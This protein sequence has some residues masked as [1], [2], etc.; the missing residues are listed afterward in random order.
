M[1]SRYR[2]PSTPRQQADLSSIK[3]NVPHT[4]YRYTEFKYLY[5]QI[6]KLINRDVVV[7][8]KYEQLRTPEVRVSLIRPLVRKLID[9]SSIQYLQTI[10]THTSV[11]T[12]NVY[13]SQSSYMDYGALTGQSSEHNQSINVIYVLLLLKYEYMIQSENNL[14]MYDLLTTKSNICE[15][16]AIRMLREYNSTERI[17]LLFINPMNCHEEHEQLKNTKHLDSF[18]TLEL[19]ILSKSKKFL[20]Q[21]VIVGILDRVYNGELIVREQRGTSQLSLGPSPS[22]R[23]IEEPQNK[24]DIEEGS[25]GLESEENS[26]ND[27]DKSIVNYKFNRITFKKV[28]DRSNTVPKYQSLVINMRYGFLT[29]LFLILVLKH[30]S[31]MGTGSY[32]VNSAFSLVFWMVALSFNFDIILRSLHIEYKFLKKIIWTY[33]DMLIVLLIDIAFVLRILLSFDKI[34]S[35]IYYNFF[36]LIPILLFPRMLSVFNN[37]EFFNLIV[38]SLKKLTWNVFAMFCLFLS[39]IFGFF[40]CFISLAVDLSIYEVAFAML[41]VFFGFTPAV[42]DNWDNYTNLGR[43]V[44]LAYLAL[45]QFV[46][47]TILAIVLSNVFVKVTKTNKQE[48]EYLKTTNLIIYLKWAAFQRSHRKAKAII[49]VFDHV[50]RIFKLP[51]ILIIYFYEILIKD[52]KRLMQKQ[53]K[54]LKH[55]TFL[56]RD[57]DLYGDSEME[58]LSSL[59]D[60]DQSSIQLMSRR[61]LQAETARVSSDGGDGIGCENEA[62]KRAIPRRLAPQKSHATMLGLRTGLL[63]SMFI[64]DYFGKKYGLAKLRSNASDVRARRVRSDVP[65]MRQAKQNEE[66]M[67]KLRELEEMIA[68]LVTEKQDG[69]GFTVRQY[70]ASDGSDG[71][72]DSEAGT[73]NFSE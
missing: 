11:A 55:F 41:K 9:L 63:D 21:P 8:F 45:M 44:Q 73:E 68:Q 65:E 72:S 37:Y 6:Q 54:D 7:T 24:R 49:V 62:K 25:T 60:N 39:L 3:L 53:R 64:D 20:S 47:T 67:K 56:S 17:T 5:F 2:V 22:A 31:K 57:A 52:N 27:F 1:A 15:I 32:G 36:S 33:A 23:Q 48:F 38:V 28:F 42:W 19:S 12:P 18:N 59:A 50:L 4:R 13:E 30:K 16:L 26:L 70:E 51:I 10:L 66:V 34:R 58:R 35:E 14:V 46:V 29:C 61:G 71:S 40:L 43:S 69:D